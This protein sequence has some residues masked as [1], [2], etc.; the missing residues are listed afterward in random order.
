[1]SSSLLLTPPPQTESEPQ[2]DPL[3]YMALLQVNIEEEEDSMPLPPF[4]DSPDLTYK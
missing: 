1:M 3:T 4:V 2:R